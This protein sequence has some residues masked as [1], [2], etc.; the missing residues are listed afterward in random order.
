MVS[1]P[2]L[3]NQG[4]VE[5]SSFR[6]SINQGDNS[7]NGQLGHTQ[8]ML[9][10]NV[11]IARWGFS[12]AYIVEQLMTES[13]S[14]TIMISRKKPLYYAG[15]GWR[16]EGSWMSCLDNLEAP[17]PQDC[18]ECQQFLGIVDIEEPKHMACF[19]ERIILHTWGCRIP[20]VSLANF[21]Q[22]T[23]GRSCPAIGLVL[24]Q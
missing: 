13:V 18:S 23:K 8:M 20:L 6:Q 3:V 2:T 12:W 4:H 16:E 7:S 11:L 22:G 17:R 15:H 5:V 21:H 24:P 10:M 9:K 1:C 19:L 14:W